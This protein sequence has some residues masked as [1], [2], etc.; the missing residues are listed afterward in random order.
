MSYKD[1]VWN[2]FDVNH[3]LRLMFNAR[4]DYTKDMEYMHELALLLC[5]IKPSR[6]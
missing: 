2:I 1:F 4:V 5:R 3:N 6:N